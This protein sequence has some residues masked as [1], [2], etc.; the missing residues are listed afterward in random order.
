MDLEHEIE[1]YPV[2]RTGEGRVVLEADK[3]KEDM[4]NAVHF[5]VDKEAKCA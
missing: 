1:K 5:N 2:S 4:N 3:G